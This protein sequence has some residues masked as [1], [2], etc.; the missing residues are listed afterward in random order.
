M[1]LRQEYSRPMPQN[2]HATPFVIS[3]RA[4]LLRR[5]P[6]PRRTANAQ[7]NRMD[8]AIQQARAAITRPA[9][10]QTGKQHLHIGDYDTAVQYL[11]QSLAIRQQIGDMAGLCAT[12]FN[13]GHIHWQNEQQDE[14]VSAWVTV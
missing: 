8:V 12:L 5:H 2:V 1:P 14:A 11:K 9:L 13:M 4:D 3:P 6:D 7:R 10:G